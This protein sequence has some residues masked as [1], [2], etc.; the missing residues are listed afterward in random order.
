MLF[1]KTD[2]EKVNEIKE[3]MRHQLVAGDINGL[4]ESVK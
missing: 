1:E 2:N 3:K 4:E